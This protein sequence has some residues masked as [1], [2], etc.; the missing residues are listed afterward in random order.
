MTTNDQIGEKIMERSP[1]SQIER[2]ASTFDD[3][4][5]YRL[6][7]ITVRYPTWWANVRKS[8]TEPVLRLNL[9]ADD[10]DVLEDARKRV[11]EA[12]GGEL[13]A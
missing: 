12:I 5:V 13:E 1:A 6:D 7:G 8:N 2:I 11:V 9:E 10:P 4:E 3:A